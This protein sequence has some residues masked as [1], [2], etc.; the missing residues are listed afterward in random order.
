MPKRA[1][2]PPGIPFAL[3]CVA[4]VK[5][6]RRESSVKWAMREES[7]NANDSGWRFYSEDDTPEFLESP[8][9]MRIVNFNAVGELFPIIYLLYFQP[10]G[11]EYMLVKDGKDDSLH[12]YD[13]NTLEGGSCPPW[14]LTTR[15]GAGTGN[16][17]RLRASGFIICSTPMSAHSSARPAWRRATLVRVDDNPHP[18]PLN[19]ENCLHPMTPPSFILTRSLHESPFEY[20]EN[21]TIIKIASTRVHHGERQE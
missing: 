5:T 18:T 9:S 8:S 13:Y 19:Q 7:E 14:S 1:A 10:V 15:S 4:S 3:A 17:G 2:A 16:N 12:W 21:G 6:L 11:S 20:L